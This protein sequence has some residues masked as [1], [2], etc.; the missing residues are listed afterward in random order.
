MIADGEVYWGGLDSTVG[1]D[2]E[3][4]LH[5]GEFTSARCRELGLQWALS[6]GPT[7]IENGEIRPDLGTYMEEPRTAVGQRADGTVVLLNLQGRQ[8]AALGVTERELAEIMAGYG[9]INAGNL[10]GGASS[11]MYYRGEYLNISNSSGGPRP[12]PTCLLVMP[13]EGGDVS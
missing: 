10:D 3:G 2:A 8:A 5:V 13:A 6:Y 7:L 1:M 9:C 11:D 12:I 4:T